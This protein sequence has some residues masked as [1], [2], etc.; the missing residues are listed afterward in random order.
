VKN[1]WFN[2]ESRLMPIAASKQGVPH[3]FVTMKPASNNTPALQDG[4]PAGDH[5]EALWKFM[6]LNDNAT[7]LIA[8]K[9]GSFQNDG[10]FLALP[11]APWQEDLMIAPIQVTP[12]DALQASWRL[13]ER[14]R[15]RSAFQ[16]VPSGRFLCYDSKTDGLSTCAGKHCEVDSADFEIWPRVVGIPTF[17]SN[18]TQLPEAAVPASSHPRPAS[19]KDPTPWYLK[20]GKSKPVPKKNQSVPWY[21]RKNKGLE[22]K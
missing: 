14:P 22:K 12:K 9:Q 17:R 20:K 4:W 2:S 5:P 6:L 18:A 11:P 8:T 21:L 7:L 3:R 13:F 1:E 16:H 15:S 19:G 10:H